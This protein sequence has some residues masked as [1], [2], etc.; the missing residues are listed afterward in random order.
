MSASRRPHFTNRRLF[1]LAGILLAAAFAGFVHLRTSQLP[2]VELFLHEDGTVSEGARTGKRI[3]PDQIDVSPFDENNP[4][5]SRK[6]ILEARPDTPL[7]AWNSTFEHL[8]IGGVNSFQ[9]RLGKDTLDFH[10]PALD[11]NVHLT[12]GE[13][14]LEM[15]DL[16]KDPGAEYE[17]RKSN[18]DILILADESTTVDSFLKAAIPHRKS[19]V[20]LMVDDVGIIRRRDEDLTWEPKYPLVSRIRMA[21]RFD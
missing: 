3:Q 13:T 16:R 17:R 4:F 12:R 10:F 7:V 11:G 14:P 6:A 2:P 1:L 18:P 9:F 21:F 8:L 20:S 5:H 15:I 19:G